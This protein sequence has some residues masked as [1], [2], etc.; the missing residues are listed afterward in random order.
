[1]PIVVTSLDLHRGEGRRDFFFTDAE[2]AA[3]TNDSRNDLAVGTYDEVTDGADFLTR[4]IVDAPIEVCANRDGVTL[5]AR[6]K[7][8]NSLLRQ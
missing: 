2:K 6:K 4:A 3:H 5:Y 1:M 7:G 8:C